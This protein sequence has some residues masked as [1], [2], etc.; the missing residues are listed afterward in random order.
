MLWTQDLNAAW[1]LTNSILT[2]YIWIGSRL[3]E[4]KLIARHGAVYRHYQ[5]RVPALFPWPGKHLSREDAIAL[6]AQ[7]DRPD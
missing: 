4:N 3:E 7:A 5:T 1:L 2:V 6:E